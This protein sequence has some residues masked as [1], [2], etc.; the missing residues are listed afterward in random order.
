MAKPVDSASPRAGTIPRVAIPSV[1][2]PLH[3]RLCVHRKTICL[4]CD[5]NAIE[6][7]HQED[8]AGLL[9][10]RLDNIVLTHCCDQGLTLGFKA[11]HTARTRDGLIR[12]IQ[13]LAPAKT[14]DR[15]RLH[16]SLEPLD[17]TAIHLVGMAQ[18]IITCV[19]GQSMAFIP[20]S[21]VGYN[22]AR[23]PPHL[24][25]D[26]DS[27]AGSILGPVVA[28]L[29]S[30]LDDLRENEAQAVAAGLAGLLRGL[31]AALPTR[32]RAQQT[33]ADARR[34]AI[35][36]YIEQNL[37]DP[38]LGIARIEVALGTARSTM[39]RD[40]ERHGGVEHYIKRRRLE[41][42]FIVLA[43]RE[44]TGIA[45]LSQ[46]LGFSSRNH[47]SRVF[48]AEFGCRPSEVRCR[49]AI[50]EVNSGQVYGRSAEAAAKLETIASWLSDIRRH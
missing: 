21:A 17:S 10:W 33:P 11:D 20:Y 49:A 35:I 9:S 1:A 46:R 42:A 37:S 27:P 40:F 8:E 41:Q 48:S 16:N 19:G 32:S 43:H 4:T 7:S 3:Q 24:R 14:A 47:F 26:L 36:S 6:A 28:T 5:S 44:H 25:F 18:E 45:D 50:P 38:A 22:P 29:R 2:L 13:V 34:A 23:H 30:E 12:L 39:F 31:I 15:L